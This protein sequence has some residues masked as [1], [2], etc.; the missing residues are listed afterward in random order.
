MAG[1]PLGPHGRRRRRIRDREHCDLL[2]EISFCPV[3]SL[4]SLFRDEEGLYPCRKSSGGKSP[5]WPHF[6]CIFLDRSSARGHPNAAEAILGTCLL[7]LPGP[8]GG[9]N[10][11][12]PNRARRLCSRGSAGRL[13]REYERACTSG[14]VSSFQV[15]VGGPPSQDPLQEPFEPYSGPGDYMLSCITCNAKLCEKKAIKEELHVQARLRSQYD[16]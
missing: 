16:L 4:Y 6:P 9:V 8:G 3:A 5:E 7:G 11:T 1:V 13:F 14:Y 15:G 12:E 10:G 2:L